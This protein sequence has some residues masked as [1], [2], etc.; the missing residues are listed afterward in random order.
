MAASSTIAIKIGDVQYEIE[1]LKIPYLASF[2]DF[3]AISR[4]ESTQFVH[5]P[6]PLFDIALKGIISG[7]R[8][9]FRSLPADLSQHHTLCE[10]YEFLCVDILAGQSIDDIFND[11]K[12]GKSDYDGYGKT[13]GNKTKARDTAFKLLYLLLLGDFKN[14]AR[15]SAK[16]FNAVLFLVS[17]SA[18]FKWRTRRVVRDAYE[19]RFVITAKQKARLD[20]WGKKDHEKITVEDDGD[21]TTEEEESDGYFDSDYSD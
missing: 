5:G 21:V 7:Y 6:I 9:C 4:P 11:L 2:V 20:Q 18:T 12:A 1:V 19:E 8:Q 14:E 3:Q 13:K 15:D 10:T 17:H 16:V